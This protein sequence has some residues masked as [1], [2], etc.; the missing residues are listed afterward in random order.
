[1]ATLEE[2]ERLCQAIADAGA[3]YEADPTPE[4]YAAHNRASEALADFHGRTRTP[5]VGVGGDAYVVS[6]DTEE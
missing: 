5:G 2:E 4:N 6:T 1:M 3:A